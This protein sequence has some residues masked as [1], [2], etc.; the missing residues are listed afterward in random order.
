[1]K[2]GVI[3]VCQSPGLAFSIKQMLPDA[4][5]RGYDAVAVKKENRS[6]EAAYLKQCDIVF[7]HVLPPSYQEL[8]TESLRAAV[9]GKFRQ[10][11]HFT[12]TG[13]HPDLGY[14]KAPDGTLATTPLGPYNSKIIAASY[15][16]GIPEDKVAALFREDV[17]RELEYFSEYEKA[18]AFA[19]RTFSG[20]GEGIANA[21]ARWERR[22]IFM[23]TI[24]HPKSFVV[25]DLAAQLLVAEGL[26]AE[27]P[28]SEVHVADTLSVGAAWP[29]YP[30]IARHLNYANGSYLF[31]SNGLPSGETG[32]VSLLN[33]NEFIGACYHSYAGC[34]ARVFDIPVLEKV[35]A[36][37]KQA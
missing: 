5:V 7:S 16:L 36:V 15:S 20:M 13:L 2:I 10:M 23:Y 17:F 34:A 12:F 33:L 27:A 4:Q 29:V 30:A 8:A 14:I 21:F 25:F 18:K 26:L 32:R 31:K 19:L 3:G 6:A 24:N 1:M 35:R 22:G 37:L 9:G 28:A 11:S